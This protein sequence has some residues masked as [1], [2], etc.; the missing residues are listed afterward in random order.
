VPSW[1]SHHKS[2]K[3]IIAASPNKRLID[4][5]SAG[6]SHSHIYHVKIVCGESSEMA[7]R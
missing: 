3:T 5:S 4:P 2:T 7:R 6:F 1:T